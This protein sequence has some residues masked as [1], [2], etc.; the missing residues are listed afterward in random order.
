MPVASRGLTAEVRR[1]WD[2]VGSA[3]PSSAELRG[4]TALAIH[5]EHRQ[6]ED[7]DLFVHSS[8]D[9][10][11]VLRRL[12]RLGE[13]EDPF[14]EEGTLNCVFDDVKLQFLRAVG[15]RRIAAGR[16]VGEMRVGSFP[17]VAATKLEVVGDRGELRDCYDLMCSEEHGQADIPLMLEWYCRRYGLERT[18][19]TV[20]HIVR[21]LG[22]LH[23]VA[24]DPWLSR[25]VGDPGLF[26]RVTEYWRLRQP[27]IARRLF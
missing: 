3:S 14:V 9:P 21:S 1:V 5:L 16:R 7:L 25:S 23:D 17:E 2:R 8:F 26:S 27:Q 4:G 19:Q 18:D 20:F 10:S 11:S 12:R 15:Q 24:N 13:V 6:S 22:S